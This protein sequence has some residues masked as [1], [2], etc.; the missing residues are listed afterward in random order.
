M[1]LNFFQIKMACIW[2]SV[3]SEW[4]LIYGAVRKLVIFINTKPTWNMFCV[5]E[6]LEDI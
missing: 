6:E 1:L 4:M 5:C 2:E 3:A